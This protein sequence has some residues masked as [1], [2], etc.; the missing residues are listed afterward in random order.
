MDSETAANSEARAALVKGSA[1]TSISRG[2]KL[3]R[4]LASSLDPR[5]LLHMFRMVNYYNTNH[6]R[7]RRLIRMG[8]SA[9]ISPDAIFS[10]PDRISF[11]HNIHIGSRTHIWAGPSTGRI[12]IGDDVLIGPDVM[13]T[14]ASYRFD[15]GSPVTSQVMDEGD[16]N[17]GND[18]W[19]GAKV[20]V[21]PGVSIGAGAI[22]GASA[23]V[24]KN[25]PDFAIAV[26]IPAR[27]VGQRKRTPR[28]KVQT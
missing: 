13:I 4:L 28:S 1:K 21:L 24:S 9:S 5:A 3:W 17:I 11:G 10:N 15:D 19:L 22:V 20:V 25:I 7:P 6:V 2:G 8:K 27:I 26:G 23:V 14:A 12:T 18:V 16:I